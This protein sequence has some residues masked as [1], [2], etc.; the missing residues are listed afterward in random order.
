MF[1]TYA[2]YPYP[3]PPDVKLEPLL[4]Q[5]SIFHPKGFLPK[6]V[7]V[8]AADF[9]GLLDSSHEISSHALEHHRCD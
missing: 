4:P 7:E 2:K 3:T 6:V 9:N 1:P 8:L 5:Q